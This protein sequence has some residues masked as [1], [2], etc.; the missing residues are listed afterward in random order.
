ML[1]KR[2]QC[3]GGGGCRQLRS[4]GRVRIRLLLPVPHSAPARGHPD[5]RGTTSA[6]AAICWETL[7]ANC[8]HLNAETPDRPF[9]FRTA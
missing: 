9:H 4:A 8:E 2:A 6:D 7:A 3:V 5:S 1:L